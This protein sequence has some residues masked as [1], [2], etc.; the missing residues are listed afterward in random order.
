MKKFIP[1]FLAYS[2]FASAL[3]FALSFFLLPQE[4]VASG[5]ETAYRL[6]NALCSFF[7]Y[8]PSIL[9]TSFLL[10]CS[11]EFSN[12]GSRAEIR[13]SAEIALA[14]KKIIVAALAVTFVAS[15]GTLVLLPFEQTKKSVM[16]EIPA[17]LS[18][19]LNTAKLYRLQKKPGAASQYIKRALILDP[20]NKELRNLDRQLE[21][22]QKELEAIQRAER[23]KSY[24]ETN[25]NSNDKSFRA[26]EESKLPPEQM[27]KK[28]RALL[29][30][31][32]YFGA[33]Y[34]SVQAQRLLSPE[35]PSAQEAKEISEKSW[36]RLQAAQMEELTSGN[37]FFRKK[38]QGYRNLVDGNFEEAYYIFHD[39]SLEDARKAR[40]PDVL[41]YLEEAQT[42]LL[43]NYFFIDET[44]DASRFEAANNILFAVPHANGERDVVLIRGVTEVEG[45]GGMIRY[46]RGL[47]VH[48]FDQYGKWKSSVTTPYAKMT[49]RRAK[50]L[51]KRTAEELAVNPSVKNIPFVML[52][53]VSRDSPDNKNEPVWKFKKAEEGGQSAG[54]NQLYF[55]IPYEDFSLILLSA[56][57]NGNLNPFSLNRMARKAPD[58]GYSSEVFS[59]ESLNRI[60]YPFMFLVLLIFIATIAWNYRLSAGAIFKFKWVFILP[61]LNVVFYLIVSFVEYLISLLNFVFIAMAGTRMAVLAGICVYVFLLAL[62]SVMFLSRKND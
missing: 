26:L 51:D 24:N 61:S 46:L 34:L 55:P 13:F 39:L 37:V 62:V 38:M 1:A 10:A 42:I 50:D 16:R 25:L 47:A 17:L 41:R 20:N 7:G 58:Y 32:D 23:N 14:F 29:A 28:A 45:T 30:A 18:E 59:V 2:L 44:Y 35:N 60:F 19:Y 27:T 54:A 12:A 53:S 5:S 11:I 31:K 15:L 22:E 3:A 6:A 52:R 4:A 8:L 36:A 9:L 48:S 33:H 43:K 40:D 21:A 56:A 57:G 49:A